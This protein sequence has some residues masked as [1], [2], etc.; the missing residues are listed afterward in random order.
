MPQNPTLSDEIRDFV[1][2]YKLDKERAKLL[3]YYLRLACIEFRKLCANNRFTHSALSKDKQ[4]K[5]LKNGMAFIL[6]I[7]F[8]RNY[9][10]IDN[11][12]KNFQETAIAILKLVKAF[13]LSARKRGN[14]SNPLLQ[15]IIFFILAGYE[16]AFG[17]TAKVV[18]NRH[19]KSAKGRYEKPSSFHT[20]CQAAIKLVTGEKIEVKHSTLQ[21]YITLIRK[22][23]LTTQDEEPI[24]GNPAKDFINLQQKISL[25]K[26][27][28]R[29]PGNAREVL[30]RSGVI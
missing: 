29:R 16:L 7:D 23:F 19:S 13:P 18:K 4:A 11:E 17:E 30:T 1:S 21:D 22:A 14:K 28:K 20:F 3:E 6:G 15:Q 8:L 12:I 24:K 25:P 2:G 10:E 5:I 27:A 26:I 9:V